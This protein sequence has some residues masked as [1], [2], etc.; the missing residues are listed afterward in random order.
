LSAGDPHINLS[1]PG[2]KIERWGALR[3]QRCSPQRVSG[4]PA[5]I[6]TVDPQGLET[7]TILALFGTTEVMP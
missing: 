7:R 1:L 2:L 3:E 5:A 6:G 4:V